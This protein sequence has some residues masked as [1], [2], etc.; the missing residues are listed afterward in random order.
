MVC[1]CVLLQYP[2]VHC[3]ALPST[4]AASSAQRRRHRPRARG[5]ARAKLC[6]LVRLFRKTR[7]PGFFAVPPALEKNEMGPFPSGCGNWARSKLRR[8]FTPSRCKR[9][10]KNSL[11]MSRS[12]V[13]SGLFYVL[14][15]FVLQPL[16]KSIERA[17]KDPSST[18]K[19]IETE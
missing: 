16:R 7:P 11:R 9:S 4:A 17:K 13:S 1:V 8:G 18:V 5:H 15:G 19:L 12:G 10:I 2:L 14:I 3:A 6:E